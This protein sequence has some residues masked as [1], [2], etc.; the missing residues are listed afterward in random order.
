MLV[1][2][3]TRYLEHREQTVVEGVKIG[4]RFQNMK[5][6]FSNWEF[7]AKNLSTEKRE[8]PEEEK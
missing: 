3:K 8:N 5:A 2:K 1:E 6:L 7:S 4:T